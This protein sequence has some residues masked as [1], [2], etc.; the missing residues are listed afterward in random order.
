[1][2]SIAPRGLTLLL[3][4]PRVAP[5]LLSRDAWLALDAADSVLAR[6]LQDPLAAAVIASGIEVRESPGDPPTLARLSL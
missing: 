4:S 2:T 6:S 3:T 1:M 5:G